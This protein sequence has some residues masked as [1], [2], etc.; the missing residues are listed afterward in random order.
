MPDVKTSPNRLECG[1]VLGPVFEYCS[2]GRRLQERV[3]ETYKRMLEDRG[4]REG[5]GRH[6]MAKR[7]RDEHF[8][9]NGID[10]CAPGRA[11][12]EGRPE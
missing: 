12:A 11:A 5:P 1:C 3:R 2:E 7:A 10:R 8:R 4:D 6:E 9:R